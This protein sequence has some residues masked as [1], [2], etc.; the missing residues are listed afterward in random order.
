M[1]V[2][3]IALEMRNERKVDNLKEQ[4]TVVSLVTPLGEGGIGKIIVSGLDALSIVNKAF[5][6]KGIA[7]L[8]EATSHKLYYGYI[9]DRGQKIDE[10]I[11]TIIKQED[12]FTGEDVVEVNCHGGIRVLM[13][14]H[15]CL[16]SAGAVDAPWNALLTRSFANGRIDFV[17]KEAIQEIIEI[18]TRLGAKVL[19]DQYNGALSG[20]LKRGLEIIEEI[21]HFFSKDAFVSTLTNLIRELLETASFGMALTTPQVLVILGKPNVGKST[22]IN[23]ILGEERMLVHHE[24][25][26]TRDYVSEFISVEGIPFELVDTAGI[27]TTTDKLEAMSIEMTQEQLQRADKVIVVFD[28][29]R[30]FD[31][32]DDEILR[33]LHAWLMSKTSGAL[34]QKA[35]TYAI[36]PVVNKCDLPAILDKRRIESALQRPVCALS[37]LN[38]DGFDEMNKRLTEEFDTVYKPMRPVVFNT[39]QYQL[40]AKANSFIEKNMGCLI[41][42]QRTGEALHVIDALKKTFTA[43]LE[44]QE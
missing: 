3:I 7:D 21:R 15:E 13:R 25:G 8:R 16:Q 23:A 43:C 41:T 34:P 1:L 2:A 26:T 29:A 35:H 17:Q 28:N 19:L 37:A 12:S 6:G 5:Q 10:V 9:Q 24:P 38:K 18:R 30:P 20:A 27:R 14:I 40:L 44:G 32:E 31:K 22:I 4:K 33:T 42:R 11:V 39:R 36:I